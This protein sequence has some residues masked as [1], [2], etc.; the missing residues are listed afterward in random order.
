VT[1]SQSTRLDF[2]HCYESKWHTGF[3]RH[4]SPKKSLDSSSSVWQRC[5]VENL[6][7]A[8]YD[9]AWSTTWG[10][11]STLQVEDQ[12][13]QISLRMT[14]WNLAVLLGKGEVDLYQPRNDFWLVKTSIFL[15]WLFE[16]TLAIWNEEHAKD[17]YQT[18]TAP[19]VR[20]QPAIYRLQIQALTNWAILA[21]W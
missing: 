3:S 20:L 10:S 18:N 4:T 8:S 6:F 12:S 9:L 11:V 2:P 17:P 7:F 5:Q 13:A 19:T 15:Q 16:L 14:S 21:S 1:F